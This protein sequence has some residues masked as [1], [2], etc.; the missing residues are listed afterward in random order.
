MGEKSFEWFTNKIDVDGRRE[1]E[2]VKYK[3]FAKSNPVLPLEI[4]KSDMSMNKQWLSLPPISDIP[5]EIRL[6]TQ[7]HHLQSIDSLPYSLLQYLLTYRFLVM[8]RWTT[9]N[10]FCLNISYAIAFVN[11]VD[12]VLGT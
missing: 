3:Y 7:R 5:H 4:D 6:I 1:T 11:V 2:S 9:L 10:E 12:A 8:L